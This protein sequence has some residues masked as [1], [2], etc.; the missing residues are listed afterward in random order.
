M[1]KSFKKQRSYDEYDSDGY[2]DNRRTRDFKNRR[3]EK[4]L[5]N[6]L[7]SMKNVSARDLQYYDE[8]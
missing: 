6:N 2:N 3:R 7:R 1:G 4:Q 8:D 5:K